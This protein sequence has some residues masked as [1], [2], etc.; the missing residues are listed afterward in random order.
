MPKYQTKAF[1]GI[2]PIIL[3]R[4]AS[5]MWVPVDVEFP[6]V[7]LVA[8]DLLEVCEL[9][10][11][12]KCVDWALVP[13]DADSGGAPALAFS[14]GVE[15]AGGTDLG[16]EVWGTGLTGAQTGTINR[17]SSSVSAQGDISANRKIA[18]KCTN[19]AQTYAGAGKTGQLML[20]LT[21]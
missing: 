8:N 2:K 1:K 5:A 12:V 16:T 21:A 11:G 4:D 3:P 9:P 15:N 14:L 17:A 6:S 7:A 13:P 20:L 10:I 19:A 18:L